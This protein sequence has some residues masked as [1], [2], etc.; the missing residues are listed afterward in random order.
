MATT[1]NRWRRWPKQRNQF[2]SALAVHPWRRSRTGAP[3]GPSAMRANVRPRPGR[4]T[5]R[6]GGSGGPATDDEEDDEED[7][8]AAGGTRPF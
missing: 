8:E 4:S 3:G 5:T 7:A 1:V 6:P 2:R